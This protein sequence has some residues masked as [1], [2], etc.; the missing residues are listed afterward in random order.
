MDRLFWVDFSCKFV[1]EI[2]PFQRNWIPLYQFNPQFISGLMKRFQC[3]TR[4]S[5]LSFSQCLSP[6]S[7]CSASSAITRNQPLTCQKMGPWSKL[8]SIVRNVNSHS[9]GAVSHCCVVI[10]LLAIYCLA[11]Q[12]L[13]L[14]PR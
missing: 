8:H 6:F 2:S 14:E 3:K 13:L 12:P 11:L 7:Q 5:L 9:F 10:I 1:F 4:K